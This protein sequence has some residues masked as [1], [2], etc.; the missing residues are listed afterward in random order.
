M[1]ISYG[2]K[3]FIFFTV[4][5]EDFSLIIRLN[6]FVFLFIYECLRMYTRVSELMNFFNKIV[7]SEWWVRVTTVYLRVCICQLHTYI[8]AVKVN[9]IFMFLIKILYTHFIK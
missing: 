9:T 6:V 2:L 3:I 5:T 8:F 1:S 7:K 4:V